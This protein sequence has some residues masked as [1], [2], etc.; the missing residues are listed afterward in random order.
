[1][2]SVTATVTAGVKDIAGNVL[3][4]TVGSPGIWSFTTRDEV[5]PTVTAVSPANG[6][7]VSAPATVN[8]TFSEPMDQA[9]IIGANITLRVTSSGANVA[10]TVTYNVTTRVA[11][12]TPSAPLS[13]PANYTVTVT[14]GVKDVAGNA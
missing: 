4:L 3:Q 10:G 5:P 7:T 1:G 2:A 14:T 6:T 11:T 13:V 8:I 9:T 12:F